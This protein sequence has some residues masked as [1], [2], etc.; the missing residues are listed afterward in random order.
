MIKAR[1][2]V[3][4]F[5]PD[6]AIGVGGYASGPTLKAAQRAGIPTLIQ[7]QNS[8][9]GVTNKML[10]NGAKAICVAYDNMQRFFPCR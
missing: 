7:E 9:A 4:D 2:I 3:A 6:I 1:R 5:K 8:Y 10:A